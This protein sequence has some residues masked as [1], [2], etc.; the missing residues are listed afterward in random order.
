MA[1]IISKPL[2]EPPEPLPQGL[3]VEMLREILAYFT[4]PDLEI[5][6]LVTREQ[7]EWNYNRCRAHLATLR[8][9]CLASKKMYSI[10][11]PLL[12]SRFTN[13]WLLTVPGVY[14]Q[15]DLVQFLRTICTKPGLGFSL[16]D[17]LID[18]NMHNAPMREWPG[19]AAL[20]ALFKHSLKSLWFGYG[21]ASGNQFLSPAD[22]LFSEPNLMEA[23]LH[24]LEMGED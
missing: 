19:I 13:R 8:N 5:S 11:S 17:L 2:E 16:K 10:A 7:S 22:K 1:T 24:S 15:L 20:A 9:A 4:L 12:H 18:T 3:P 6:N 23:I 14:G 21:K